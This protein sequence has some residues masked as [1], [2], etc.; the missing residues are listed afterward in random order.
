MKNGNAGSSEK[1]ARAV[2]NGAARGGKKNGAA[3]AQPGETANHNETLLH[4]CLAEPVSHTEVIP[5]DSP[6]WPL[7]SAMWLQP[8]SVPS[9]PLWSGLAVERQNRFPMPDFQPQ[10]IA[11][12]D[13][14]GAAHN[15]RDALTTAARPSVP[16]TDLRPLGWDPRAVCGKDGKK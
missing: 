10:G 13:R 8:A 3:A 6:A 15:S 11:P 9:L 16:D 7:H 1:V 14:P 5:T 2:S 12:L 4:A